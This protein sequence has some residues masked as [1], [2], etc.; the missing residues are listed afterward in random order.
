[1][2]ITKLDAVNTMLGCIGEAPVSDLEATSNADV[3][4]AVATLDEVSKT[5]QLRGWYWNTIQSYTLS[6]DVDNKIPVPPNTLSITPRDESISLEVG[7]RN[8]FLFNLEDN[9]YVF[10][11]AVKATM[12]QL[13]EWEEL[14][15]VLQSYIQVKAAR[16]LVQ[17]VLGDG[18]EARFTSADENEAMTEA[19]RQ[20]RNKLKLNAG[21]GSMYNLA[22]GWRRPR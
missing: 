9:T 15:E 22:I 20:N 3:V 6:L 11:A 8:N 21:K 10:D 5:V 13:L 2:S 4:T 1:M 17:R 16:T 7:I 14:P 12:V 19:R 18:T